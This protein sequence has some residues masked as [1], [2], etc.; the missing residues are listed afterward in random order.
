[1]FMGAAVGSFEEVV[2][3]V[4]IVIA[5]AYTLGWDVL[6]GLGMSILA[7]CCGFSKR[8]TNPFTVGVAQ[9][10]AELP[11]FSGIL[12][13]FVGFVIIYIFLA[14]F[15]RMHIR[16][17]EKKGVPEEHANFDYHEETYVP[18]KKMDR[19]LLCF[20]IVM[21]VTIGVILSSSLISALADYLMPLVALMFLIAGTLTSLI[22]GMPLKKMLKSF[23][24]GMVSIF[25]AVLLI[26]MAGSV[27]Y[28]ITEGQILDTILNAGIGVIQQT[29]PIVSIMLIY[30]LVLV[31][32]IFVASGSAKAVL[33]MPII[34]P[35]VDI[36]NISRQTAILAYAYGD[37]FSNV[38]Y[39]TNAVLLIVLGLAGISYGKWFKFVI[40][41][42]GGI[43]VITAIL[44]II[45]HLFVYTV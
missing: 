6:T 27:K 20:L 26:L 37:G 21:G 33:L 16:R 1:M 19:A 11:L 32:E 44:L 39:P 5:L 7:V 22:S 8:R 17:I 40:K 3:L 18:D 38:L 34:I 12:Y 30:L 29:S 36:A 42:E 2:P 43:F 35:L 31:I 28:I 45:A 15:L 14:F 41:F 10:L 13:R 24:E 9:Q 23:W 4:P 25:P